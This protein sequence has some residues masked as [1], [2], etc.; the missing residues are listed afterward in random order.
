MSFFA[1]NVTSFISQILDFLYRLVCIF[2]FDGVSVKTQ[3][4]QILYL[5]SFRRE[6]T[7]NGGANH[8]PWL[9]HFQTFNLCLF[10]T[11][12][13]WQSAKGK[14]AALSLAKL[15]LIKTWIKPPW[16]MYNKIFIKQQVW[17][18]LKFFRKPWYLC[19]V[20]VFSF[21]LAGYWGLKQMNESKQH[22]H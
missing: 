1:D 9:N 17:E 10:Q 21:V 13:S 16:K 19:T 11:Q 20:F 3:N 12:F 7:M 5:L 14:K 4:R 6:G 18:C 15:W 8:T 22:F 2:I